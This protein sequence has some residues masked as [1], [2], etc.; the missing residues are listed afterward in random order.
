MC[1]MVSPSVGL[2]VMFGSRPSSAQEM[3]RHYRT[4]S[5]LRTRWLHFWWLELPGEMQGQHYCAALRRLQFADRSTKTCLQVLPMQT[6]FPRRTVLSRVTWSLSYVCR[7]KYSET[8]A[9]DGLCIGQV[10]CLHASLC[11]TK[12]CATTILSVLK[13]YDLCMHQRPIYACVGSL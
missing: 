8:D 1:I 3:G 9:T 10:S 4:I 11:C 7:V 12:M 2:L 13:T 6:I 5:L